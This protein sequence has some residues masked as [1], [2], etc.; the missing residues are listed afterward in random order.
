MQPKNG[1]TLNRKNRETENKIREKMELWR[2][3][4]PSMGEISQ[5]LAVEILLRAP[6]P[7]FFSPFLHNSIMS[8][9]SIISLFVEFFLNVSRFLHL[10]HKN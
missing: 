9:F 3:G 1:E 2:N 5:C 10:T 6:N 7:E 8:Q 4:E